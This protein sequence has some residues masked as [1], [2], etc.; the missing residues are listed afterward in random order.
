MGTRGFDFF[1]QVL[2]IWHP[3]VELDK[4]LSF[5]KAVTIEPGFQLFLF[6]GHTTKGPGIPRP[7]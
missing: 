5:L 6:A 7:F 1:E 3:F 2:S 4:R